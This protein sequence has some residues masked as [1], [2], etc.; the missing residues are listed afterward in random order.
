MKRIRSEVLKPLWSRRDIAVSRHLSTAGWLEI[1]RNF[2][3]AY[4]DR[5]RHVG[6]EKPPLPEGPYLM[7]I[8]SSLRY[9]ADT[10]PGDEAFVYIDYDLRGAERVCKISW[11]QLHSRVAVL[12]DCLTSI[13][14][15]SEKQKYA[16]ISAPQGLEYVIGFLG[17][18]Y[19]G[20]NPVP[21]PEPQGSLQDKRTGLALHD[22]SAGVVLTTARSEDAIRATAAT[23]N[24]AVTMPVIALDTLGAAYH[25]PSTD[26][27]IPSGRASDDGS[28]LQYTSGSTGLPRGA[29]ISLDNVAANVEQ[30]THSIFRNEAGGTSLPR[31]VVSWLPLYHDMGL[32]TS[33]FIPMITGCPSILMS[34]AS[35]IRKPA[36]WMRLL[37]EYEAPF[38]AGPNFAFDLAA[39]R[40]SDREMVG[41][42][43]SHV[44][45]IANGGERVQPHTMENF[46]ERFAAY[47]L[48]RAA[49]KP[50]YGM[51]EAVAYIATTKLGS[52][53]IS[54]EFDSRSLVLGRPQLNNGES[55]TRLIRYE[56]AGGEPLVRIVD[57]E[58]CTE[59]EDGRVGEIWVHGK[60]VASS[61]HNIDPAVNRDKF[62]SILR[63]KSRDTP[64]SPW[65]RTG[66][67]GFVHGDGLYIVGRI[68]DL[69]IQDGVNHYPDDIENTIRKFTGGRVAAF[70]IVDDRSE[71]LVVVA[72]VKPGNVA[73]ELSNVELATIKKQA[74]AALSRMH[75]VRLADFLLV[76]PHAIPKTTSG[77]I[78]RSAC[79][80]R[81]Q[82]DD[83]ERVEVLQ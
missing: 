70:S 42:D 56:K 7:S 22:S 40:V 49:V 20:W 9:L 79:A 23:H 38:S 12:A 25:S 17:A 43:L 75:G 30:I 48:P 81:Y 34:P 62:E 35:F 6:A 44:H 72:E 59:L 29:R 66:D 57:P 3:L 33:V 27:G 21:L 78:S 19:A 46:L 53:P 11:S 15:E 71:R 80:Q 24:L 52:P 37:A 13:D 58:S 74:A 83:F 31:S 18:I 82:A 60:N 63:T 14:G 39:N 32:M 68:K 5:G 47:R 36:R 54:T 8:I 67:L 2:L 26:V 69:I 4:P 76:P 51:A 50:S 1:Q 41:I 61:Y 64:K 16:A 45:T 10:R 28:Y 77:K 73:E 55:G 65:L